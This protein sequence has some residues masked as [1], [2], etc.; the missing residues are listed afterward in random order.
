MSGAPGKGNTPATF[1]ATGVSREGPAEGAE[2]Q[3]V[4]W[5]FPDD[6]EK[7]KS[8][9]GTIRLVRG[10]DARPALGLA[11]VPVGTVGAFEITKKD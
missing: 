7:V 6:N 5:V 4:G 8:V 3:L 9:N 10:P 1:E 2:Y 11:E